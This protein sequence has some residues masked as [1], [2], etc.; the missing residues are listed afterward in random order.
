V[1]GGLLENLPIEAIQSKNTILASSVQMPFGALWDGKTG[2]L[3]FSQGT[4]FSNSY[5]L[6]RKSIVLMILENE[7]RSL[8]TC[9][10]AKI[11]H[12][13]DGTIE[14][15]AFSRSEEIIEGAYLQA[16]NE[17]FFEMNRGG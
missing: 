17:L 13:S 9:P 5:A 7:R 1:D 11:F 2:N 10:S 12:Y 6:L 3:I 14:Y 8:A 15:H 16:K 4:L